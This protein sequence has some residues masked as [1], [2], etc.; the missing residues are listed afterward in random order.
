[1]SD[2]KIELTERLRREGRWAE[3][4]RFKDD[5]VARLRAQGM[6]RAEARED[7]WQRMAAAF[8][9]LAIAV[10]ASDSDDSEA[11]AV[12]SQVE[13]II[14]ILADSA[15]RE[16]EHWQQTY[17]IPLHADAS[18]ALVGEVLMYFWALGSMRKPA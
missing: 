16:V 12:D 2:S 6:R 18:A 5:I 13:E 11:L 3:A 1:M 10:P 14:A 9:P 8:S 4:S 15:T 17:Q 7:A